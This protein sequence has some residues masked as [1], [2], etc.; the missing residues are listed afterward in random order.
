V[1]V[2]FC[3]EFDGGFG[4]IVEEFLERCSH[5]LVA[6]RRVWLIDPVAGDGVEERIRAAGEAAG[7][8]QLLDRHNRD[9][10]ELA[11]RLGVPHHLVPHE[12]IAEAPFAFLTI[13]EG[14]WWNEVALWWPD[15][16]V[17]VSGD[18]LGTS[19]YYQARGERIA[20]HPLLR[21]RPPRR[22]LGRLSPDRILCGH[23][24]GIHARAETAL[25]E[26][27]RTAR[28]RIP[29]QVAASVRAWLL[30]R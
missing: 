9:C 6:D 3:D 19:R 29:G 7:V 21:L 24:E 23:G 11:R 1:R 27:L 20:V 12:A 25:R 15:E 16:R 22:Q 17:L 4:W 10:A 18:A 28:R 2:R 8:I 14:R 13:R 26:A 5:A 30:A